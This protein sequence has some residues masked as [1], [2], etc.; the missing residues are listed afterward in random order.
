M[1]RYTLPRAIRQQ[2]HWLTLIILMIPAMFETQYQYLYLFGLLLFL[3][4]TDST[5]KLTDVQSCSNT[6]Y[7]IWMLCAALTAI[8]IA[9]FPDLSI[10]VLPSIAYVAIPEEWF[11]RAYLM[12]KFRSGWQAILIVSL[13]FALM[14]FTYKNELN[15]WLVFIPSLFYCWYYLLTRDLLGVILLHV[16]S[17]IVYIA[18]IQELNFRSLL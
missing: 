18:F 15:A 6:A 9:A 7:A 4:L 13:L 10:H 1:K 14:H 2:Y 17:N 16:T 5:V 8:V 3:P 12:K 11:F